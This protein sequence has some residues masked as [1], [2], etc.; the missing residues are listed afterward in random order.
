M[1]KSSAL[2]LFLCITSAAQT[3]EIS[4]VTVN[5]G[6]ANIFRITLKPLPGKPLAALQW[7]LVYR[8][9]FRIEPSGVVSGEASES[10]GKSVICV[11]KAPEGAKQRL[12]CILTGGVQALAAGV[13]AIVRVEANPNAPKGEELVELE[14]VVG[15]SPALEPIPMKATKTPITIR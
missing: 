13:L 2:L 4:P 1:W 15:V 12:S 11:R 14:N 5:S 6:S 10:A 8:D 3:V 7:D 9:Y